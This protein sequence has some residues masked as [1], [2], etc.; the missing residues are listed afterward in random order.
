MNNHPYA[1]Q[2]PINNDGEPTTADEYNKEYIYK[3]R[4]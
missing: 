2:Y 1:E 3:N 4:K